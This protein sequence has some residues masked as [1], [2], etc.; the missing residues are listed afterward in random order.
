MTIWSPDPKPASL[1]PP[2]V[3]LKSPYAWLTKDSRMLVCACLP[4]VCDCVFVGWTGKTWVALCAS[5]TATNLFIPFI[6][7][8]CCKELCKRTLPP[9]CAATRR[10]GASACTA[11]CNMQWFIAASG[12]EMKT[13]SWSTKLMALGAINVYNSNHRNLCWQRAEQCLLLHSTLAC[14]LCLHRTKLLPAPTSPTLQL[15][16]FDASA[17]TASE[18]AAAYPSVLF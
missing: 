12:F 7:N 16:Q 9:L 17:H 4:S 18:A 5:G 2:Q 8:G 6:F 10:P 15:A 11:S 13:P 1:A 14:K 3:C